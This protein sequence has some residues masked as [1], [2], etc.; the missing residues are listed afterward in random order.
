[1]DSLP[2]HLK[3]IVS[4]L[5]SEFNHYEVRIK[6]QKEINKRLTTNIKKFINAYVDACNKIA[7]QIEIAKQ[8]SATNADPTK[9]LNIINSSFKDALSSTSDIFVLTNENNVSE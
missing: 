5:E 3:M 8:S 1:M 6:E 2:Q 9:I 4:V 7:I